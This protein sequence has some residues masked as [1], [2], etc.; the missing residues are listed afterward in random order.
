MASAQAAA[1]HPAT[2]QS[3]SA[4][5][6]T[7]TT[8]DSTEAEKVRRDQFKNQLKKAIDAATPKPKTE[9]EAENVMKSGGTRASVSLR[10][11]LATE[12]DAAAGPLKSAA[13]GEASPA[14]QPAPPASE[15]HPEPVGAPPAPVSAAPVVPA[16]LP[17]ERLDYSEDRAPTEQAMAQ[18]EVTQDQLKEG[19][20]PAFG[21]TIDARSK[22][23]QHE[24]GAEAR[25][26]QSE[27]KVQNSA[28][29]AAQA[30][31]TTDLD[32]MHGIKASHVGHVVGQQHATVSKDATE[33]E[34]ITSTINGIKDRTRTEVGN[35]LGSM[36]SEA[37]SV[38]EAGLARAEKAYE[39]T[40][41]DAKGGVGT[42]LTT[43]GSDWEKLI[44]N[45]LAK[46]RGEYMRQVDVAIDEVAN[47]VDAKLD[48]AKKRVTD[49]RREVETF[50][51]S[52][53]ANLKGF[54]EE[55]LQAVS[56]DFDAMG[57][58]IDQRRDSL[59][60][61]L[62]QQYK[63]SYDRMSAAEEKLRE[64]NKSLWQRVYDA[65]VGL[66]KKI[67]AFK[68]M[69]LSVLGKA[70]SV[71][72]DIIA[73]PIRFLGNLVSGVMQG[74]KNFTANIGTHL[75]KGLMDWLFGALAGAGLQLPDSFDLKG[76]VSIVLQVLGLTYANFRKR[77]AAIVGES[78]VAALEQVAD[79]FKVFLKEGVGGIWRFI[80][81]KV[82]DLKSM[83]LDAIFDFVKEKV[84]MA[85][86]T[87]IIG[88]LNPASA[89][90]KAC[91]AIY[92]IVMFFV[93]R[94][95]QILALVNAVID[96]M[97]SIAKGAIGVAAGFV[98]NALA[99]AIPVAIG[100]LASLL[101]LGD[102]S[103]PVRGFID[104]ARGPVDKAIDWVINLAVKA[105]KAAGKFIAGLFG[106]KEKDGEKA[107]PKS[108]KGEV[109]AE[110]AKRLTADHTI[111]EARAI[112][113]N[114][115]EQYRSAGV[116]RLFVSG[117]DEGGELSVIVEMSPGDELARLSPGSAIERASVRLNVELTLSA[118]EAS[119]QGTV[120][121]TVEESD[122]PRRRDGR[123]YEYLESVEKNAA[124]KSRSGISVG[125]MIFP[126]T[127][128]KIQ[129]ITWNTSSLEPEK[130]SNTTHAERQ[131]DHWLTNLSKNPEGQK[132]LDRVIGIEMHLR[133]Y[134]P[135]QA[136]GDL[137]P[138]ITARMPNAKTRKLYWYKQYAGRNVA[139]PT[140]HQTVNEIVGCGWSVYAPGTEI[141]EGG[142]PL[143]VHLI[144]KLHK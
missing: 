54:G 28:Q 141:P 77:A 82:A 84:I 121:G 100:F 71:I 66:V 68:D 79:V 48:A 33:R 143:R 83:V 49:G 67:L 89:F 132:L 140:T 37:S 130:R 111:D 64:E 72:S 78:V 40:F 86:V 1:V 120:A 14:S 74:L 15:L 122:K 52:L 60:D 129:L 128:G 104:K 45:S 13:G 125:G 8:L 142:G 98:E 138:S 133:D 81:E 29:G 73:H 22:A 25:Y 137:F 75:K 27:A 102:P 99:K 105:I 16:P 26:R 87:W 17:P 116:S 131:F 41:E 144:N 101:G 117:P 114:V 80:K 92:D 63:D 76:I 3:R 109:T 107:S 123:E 21:P 119:D 135:C 30:A 50:V 56:S 108:V 94:G 58:E 31:L 93:N 4:A 127:R 36:E 39:D 10:D 18:S 6:Q 9:S 95:S 65:T 24:A 42:W 97:A 103:K 62:A 20:E 118:A 7:I 11:N 32:G 61:K 69:L 134:S 90:F 110:L 126:E 59:I 112:V 46:A 2:E 53:D 57:S 88:L 5:T 12:R 44:E 51:K 85:G 47:L 113:T 91:K 70:A 96:S 43:W 38:F 106:K 124:R 19:N 55:A 35:I 136:C 139:S 34:R 23:E 115:G